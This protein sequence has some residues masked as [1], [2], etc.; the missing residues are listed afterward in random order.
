MKACWKYT[1]QIAFMPFPGGVKLKKPL[2]TW[3]EPFDQG[4]SRS[5]FMLSLDGIDQRR[6]EKPIHFDMKH[7]GLHYNSNPVPSTILN[8][9]QSSEDNLRA[10]T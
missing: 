2:F 3:A 5:D 10:A 4:H 9:L 8:N 7:E 6:V 1:H